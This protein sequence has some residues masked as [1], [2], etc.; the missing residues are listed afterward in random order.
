M[1]T[2]VAYLPQAA[3]ELG[4]FYMIDGKWKEATEYFTKLQK[5]CTAPKQR[6]A[7]LGYAKVGGTSDTPL[8]SLVALGG[9]ASDR[10]L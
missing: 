4:R 8:A 5:K 1:S 6:L 3:F 9:R 10:N 7:G 2:A